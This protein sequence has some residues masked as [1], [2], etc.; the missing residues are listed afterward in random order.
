M[1]RKQDKVPGTDHLKSAMNRIAEIE[2]RGAGRKHCQRL[3]RVLHHGSLN[4]IARLNA[5]MEVP[6]KL[7][8][9]LN[10]LMELMTSIPAAP[11]KSTRRNSLR[12]GES[13]ACATATMTKALAATNSLD[14]S[15]TCP[16]RFAARF[17]ELCAYLSPGATLGGHR[18]RGALP[19]A[20]SGSA[21][22]IRRPVA[23]SLIMSALLGIAAF[24]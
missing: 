2:D 20:R 8:P 14:L 1:N 22:F 15:I 19:R 13:C 18:H 23:T 12:C 24:P 6:R 10:S 11:D 17:V 16:P 3:S 4:H 5:V 9:G 7:S 21:P